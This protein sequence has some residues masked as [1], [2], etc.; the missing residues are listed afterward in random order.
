[1]HHEGVPRP[2]WESDEIERFKRREGYH[3]DDALVL[4]LGC[5][6]CPSEA[7]L[8]VWRHEESGQLFLMCEELEHGWWHPD[9]VKRK[10]CEVAPSGLVLANEND[11]ADS[12]WDEGRFR[13]KE[14]WWTN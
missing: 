8:L 5:W 10:S 14:R 9:D 7:D 13:L 4:D 1:V 12:D 2:Q 11:L 3:R 6:S